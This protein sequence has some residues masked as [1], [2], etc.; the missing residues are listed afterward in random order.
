MTEMPPAIAKR[1]PTRRP[2]QRRRSKAT[3]KPGC[4]GRCRMKRIRRY[5]AFHMIARPSYMAVSFKHRKKYVKT[6]WYEIPNHF[7]PVVNIMIKVGL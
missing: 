7:Y 5:T 6:Y 3:A 4:A 1:L 2:S